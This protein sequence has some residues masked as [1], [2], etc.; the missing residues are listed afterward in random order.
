[1]TFENV[2]NRMDFFVC[3]REKFYGNFDLNQIK[4]MA[5]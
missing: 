3:V 4:I 5:L 2:I 1:M